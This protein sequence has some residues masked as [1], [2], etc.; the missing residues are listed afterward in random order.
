MWDMLVHESTFP[1]KDIATLKILE[2]SAGTGALLRHLTKVGAID[3][4]YCELCPEFESI[5]LSETQDAT[6]HKVGT[7]FIKLDKKGYY[8]LVFANPPFQSDT[9]HLKKM[10]EVVREGG[11]VCTLMGENFHRDNAKN[12]FEG[13]CEKWGASSFF[14]TSTPRSDSNDPDEWVFEKT[15]A[16]YTLLVLQKANQKVKSKK[17]VNQ[18]SLFV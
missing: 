3:I 18:I 4:D 5:L 8:D 13:F 7:D 14:S 6:I 11:Y 10:L 15:P 1:Y 9:K 16:G 2:P 12:D 17:G